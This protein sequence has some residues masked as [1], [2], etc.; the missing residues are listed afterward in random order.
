MEPEQ[1]DVNTLFIR[2]EKSNYIID[3]DYESIQAQFPDSRIETI[4]GVGHWVHAEAPQ[5]FFRIVSEFIG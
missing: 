3:S 2:G 5:E 1:V 4:N